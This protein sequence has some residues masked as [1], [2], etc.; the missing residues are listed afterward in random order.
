[1]KKLLLITSKAA[2]VL[3]LLLW[4]LLPIYQMLLLSLTP[5]GETF[6][7]RIWPLHPTLDNFTTVLHQDHF[8]LRHFWQQLGNS[9]FVGVVTTTLVL[10]TAAPAG[11]AITR[12][13]SRW[14]R[15]ISGA[16]LMSYLV[17]SVFLSIPLYKLMGSIGLLNSRWALILALTGFASPFAVWVLCQYSASIPQE[18]DDAA[19][20]DGATPVQIFRMIYLPLMLPGL[21]AIGTHAMLVSWNEYLY[22]FMLLSSETSL[23]VP[24][25]LGY[26]LVTDDAPWNLLMATAIIYAI[27]PTALYYALRR[28][29]TPGFAAGT[30]SGQ[31]T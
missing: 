29:M 10:V 7:G 15:K 30:N 1:M 12:L 17:P 27:P 2:V 19:R 11:Y 3:L 31:Q 14:G 5:T 13:R 26:F 24:V 4:S 16:A 23:T 9:L 21:I 22:A 20:L 6:A 8:F 28:Y 18:L 25:M